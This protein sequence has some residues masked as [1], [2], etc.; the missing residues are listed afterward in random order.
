MYRDVRGYTA[1]RCAACT[2]AT[3]ASR[4]GKGQAPA[5]PVW[6][7]VSMSAGHRHAMFNV[8]LQRDERGTYDVMSHSRGVT[9]CVAYDLPHAEAQKICTRERVLR[10]AEKIL[11]TPTTISELPQEFQVR[12]D[13]CKLAEWR[14]V[15]W[16]LA[17]WISKKEKT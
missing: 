12:L 15:A 8:Y 6:A 3:K 5:I 9:T 10:A 16:D 17:E 7:K 11:R 13:A 4:S 14:R 1:Y 2:A